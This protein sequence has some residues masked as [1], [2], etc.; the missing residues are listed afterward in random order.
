MWFQ[1]LMLQHDPLKYHIACLLH[2]SPCSL[3]TGE[4]A[5]TTALRGKVG[6]VSSPPPHFNQAQ[7]TKEKECSLPGCPWRHSC[8][9]PAFPSNRARVFMWLFHLRCVHIVAFPGSWVERLQA[10]PLSPGYSHQ[11]LPGTSNN[12]PLLR[13]PEELLE[14]CQPPPEL[15]RGLPNV[16]NQT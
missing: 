14:K 2:S 10:R 13:N 9:H 8:G 15:Y 12:L 4:F 1:V 16:A 6:D 3:S 11:C 7:K 5:W